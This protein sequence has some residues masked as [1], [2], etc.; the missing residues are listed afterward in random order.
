M[1]P[2]RR[3]LLSGALGVAGV[4]ALSACS[5][6]VHSGVGAVGGTKTATAR[7][8]SK[9]LGR[10]KGQISFAYWGANDGEK[11]AFQEVARRFERA[12][13]GARVELKL[14]PY[15]GFYSGIDRSIQAG[16]APDVFR[17]EYTTVGK[18][19]SQDVLLDLTP[20]FTQKEADA[21]APAPWNAMKYNGS[22]FGVPH[23]SDTSCIAYNKAAF[24]SAG[25]TSV[26]DRL[27]DAW[28]WDEF[29]AVATKLRRSLPDNKYP[30]AYDWTQAGAMR[31]SSFLYQ[32][33]GR[34][35]RPDGKRSQLPD[36]PSRKAMDF[37]KGFFDK[38]WVPANNTVKT[39]LYA[40]NFFL[41]QI[42]PMSFV[43]NFLVPDLVDPAKGYKGGAWGATYL[44]RDKAAA[45]E[46]GG[47]AIVALAS[48]DKHDLAVAFLR[49]LVSEDSMK[50]FCEQ[51][52]ELP[53]L[54][55]LTPEDLT[56]AGRPDV[57]RLCARQAQTISQT[58]VRESTVPVFAQ[59]STVLQDQLELGF[60]D[61]STDET[62]RNIG[63][64]IDRA[65]GV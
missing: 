59:I 19:S 21:F 36:A 16:E 10:V 12:N 33:G 44:P 62:L 7:P 49:F 1:R 41:S 57:V 4:G 48:G 11:K 23:Q 38:K 18:Y 56:F 20:Y 47:N 13:P 46:L 43:G 26:P 5:S 61:Q 60:H 25:I 17:V 3:N 14:S 55:S 53:T 30:F 58:V 31:W 51:A 54:R 42:V 39:S 27:D 45:A 34:L 2:T 24:R 15:D 40:D 64:G 52:T 9:T 37:T 35:L 29:S 65:L 22:V 6:S 8:G 50:Y 28:S 32:A 63:D